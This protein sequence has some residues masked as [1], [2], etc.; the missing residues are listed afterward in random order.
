[1]TRFIDTQ[2]TETPMQP[3]E[4]TRSTTVRQQVHNGTTQTARPTRSHAWRTRALAMPSLVALVLALALGTTTDLRAV[5]AAGPCGTSG[6]FT[7]P[8][9]CTYKQGPDTFTVPVGVSSIT[10]DALGAQG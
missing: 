1:M 5:Q 2:D 3:I 4:H 10:V 9:T 8:S 7:A 6:V